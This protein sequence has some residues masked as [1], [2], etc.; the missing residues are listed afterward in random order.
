MCLLCSCL[1][2]CIRADGQSENLERKIQYISQALMKKTN[3]FLCI[4]TKILQKVAFQAL[5]KKVF[6]YFRVVSRCEMGGGGGLVLV[7][8]NVPPWLR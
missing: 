4:S 2:I 3:I 5:R 6:S 8:D 1:S 7:G